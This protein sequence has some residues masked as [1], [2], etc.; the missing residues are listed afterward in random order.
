MWYSDL[1][2][3]LFFDRYFSIDNFVIL[4]V[5]LQ[6]IALRFAACS[7][8]NFEIRNFFKMKFLITFAPADQL[9]QTDLGT[10][11][12]GTVTRIWC[13]LH[14]RRSFRGRWRSRLSFLCLALLILLAFLIF[15]ASRLLLLLLRWLLLIS[16]IEKLRCHNIHCLLTALWIPNQILACFLG[17]GRQA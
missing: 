15:L 2:Y 11:R 3:I 13:A 9:A 6:Q 5:K 8:Q 14:R 7:R 16:S 1:I 10:R 4:A 12:L 17:I